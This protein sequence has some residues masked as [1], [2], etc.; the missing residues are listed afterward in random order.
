MG[1]IN[2]VLPEGMVNE[3]RGS[4]VQQSTLSQDNTIATK[5]EQLTDAEQR[6]VREFAQK[7]D[8]HNSKVVASYGVGAQKKLGSLTD[9]SLKNVTGRDTGQVGELLLEMSLS[10][11]D[12]DKEA[13]NSK[14]PGLLRSVKTKTQALRVK[15]ENVTTTLD[16]IA[17]NLEDHR[18]T[19]LNDIGMLDGMYDD[20][21]NYF[22]EITMYILAG[23]MK[24]DE[25]RKGELEDLR[26][27]ADTTK[28]PEDAFQYADL[29]NRCENFDKQL[30]DLELTRAVCL[31]SAP[32]I[33]LVQDTDNNLVRKIQSSINNS[34]PIWKQKLGVALALEHDRKSA[35]AQK[36]VT[37][38]TS[39]MLVSTAEM[40][41]TGVVESAKEA[42]RGIVNIDDVLRSNTELI[43]TIKD[44][45]AV[46]EQGRT[47]RIEAAAKLVEA[48]EDLR[49]VLLTAN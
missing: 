7:I 26:Q 22:K 43:N 44:V 39:Q 21:L 48:E 8:L 27:K 23:R 6:Q 47:A 40:L 29:R 31:Q 19:L 18:K 36:T 30:H 37:D 49:A 2:L 9:K 17:D 24:L 33:R 1:G 46:R 10:I 38:L 28:A 4:N 34:I 5:I 13:A 11:K 16:R 41:H 45:I 3:P 32:Q 42:E 25:I 35:L 12:F 14:K 20:N 15:Y